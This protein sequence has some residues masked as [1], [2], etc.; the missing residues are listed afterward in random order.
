MAL[1]DRPVSSFTL[2]V[3]LPGN[4]ASL[5]QEPLLQY[6]FKIEKSKYFFCRVTPF[7]TF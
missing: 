4:C 7:D 1:H 2:T 6:Y 5:S 3:F